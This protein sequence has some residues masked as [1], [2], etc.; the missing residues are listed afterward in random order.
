MSAL[1]R[2]TIVVPAFNEG[3]GIFRFVTAL[4]EYLGTNPKFA[5]FEFTVIVVN[6]G[7]S[8]DTAVHLRAL[9]SAVHPERVHFRWL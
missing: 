9:E 2:G 1:T 5:T 8:D 4:T 3:Q 7:S 6:D